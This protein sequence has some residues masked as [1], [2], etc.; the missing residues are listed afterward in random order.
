M[1]SAKEFLAPR[2]TGRRFDD[3]T[4][5]LEL[6]EDFAAFEDLLIEVAKWQF[7][8]DNPERKSVPRGFLE[9]IS[10]KLSSV[11]EGSAVPKIMLVATSA[12]MLDSDSYSYFERAKQSIICAIDAATTNKNILEHIPEHLL[13]YFNQIGKRLKDDESIDFS[14]DSIYNAKLNRASRTK[15]VL[16]SSNVTEIIIE[17]RLRALIPEVDKSA[18]SFSMLLSSGRMLKANI[19]IE[20]RNVIVAAFN[21]FETKT[22]VLISGMGRFNAFDNSLESFES[23]NHI[24]ILDP[25][26]IAYRLEELSQ[27]ENGWFNGTG[28]APLKEHLDWF[29]ELFENHFDTTLPLP[30]LYP[31][32]SGGI[33]AEWA[34]GH[35]DV[36]LK[37]EF[38]TKTA[39]YQSLNHLDNTEDEVSIN[40]EKE[41]DWNL[42]NKKL[43]SILKASS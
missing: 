41:E 39:Y 20:H 16:A 40:L 42:L 32:F 7:L 37:V 34:S 12:G 22:K 36:T 19:P 1:G 25:L 29:S 13:A 10:L 17:T 6:M 11:E 23:I 24:S 31:T 2:L 5:P 28:I 15:L 8:K 18:N 27:L 14:P 21:G 35:Y 43:L 33:Q 9:G 38:E 4:I 3:H 26:D 30:Y